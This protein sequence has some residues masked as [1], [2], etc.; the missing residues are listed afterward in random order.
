MIFFVEMLGGQIPLPGPDNAALRAR[1]CCQHGKKPLRKTGLPA[2]CPYSQMAN[3]A[4]GTPGRIMKKPADSVRI[5][6]TK[7]LAAGKRLPQVIV[8]G[9]AA[10]QRIKL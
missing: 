1:P 4:G 10:G 2:V 8:S 3:L 5:G 7:D 9:D 6:K